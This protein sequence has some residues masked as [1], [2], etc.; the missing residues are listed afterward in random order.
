MSIDEKTD[1]NR[2]N[3]R[4]NVSL[5]RKI[6]TGNYESMDFHASDSRDVADEEDRK[7]AFRVLFLDVL[8]ELNNQLDACG[9][10]HRKTHASR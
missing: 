6:N 1:Q 5:G 7:E 3:H 10:G 8:G 2:Q 4:I 9:L